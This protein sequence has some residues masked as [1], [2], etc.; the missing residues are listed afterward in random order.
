MF[1]RWK[2]RK[3]RSVDGASKRGDSLDA[4]VVENYREGG[5]VRQRV[6]CHL[7]VVHEKARNETRDRFLFWRWTA[8]KL[9]K[10]NLKPDARTRIEAQLSA[11]IP[12]MN[13]RE[14][15]RYEAQGRAR[16]NQLMVG[17]RS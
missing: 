12:K 3:P 7:G 16:F 4:V 13:K 6:I 5:K 17:R 1:V 9:N 14:I 11:K 2:R 8:P 15:D 10:L